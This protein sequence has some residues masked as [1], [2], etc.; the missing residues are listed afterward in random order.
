MRAQSTEP[1]GVQFGSQATYMRFTSY[2][3][4][5]IN[6]FFTLTMRWEAVAATREVAACIQRCVM[7]PFQQVRGVILPMPPAMP[8]QTN[9][10]WPRSCA[11]S[12]DAP[13]LR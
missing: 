12:F 10:R 11:Q 9:C 4:E 13:L 3:E 5:T 8:V 7:F 6:T 1:S 2:I